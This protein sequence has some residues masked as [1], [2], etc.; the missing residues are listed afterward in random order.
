MVVQKSESLADCKAA[1]IRLRFLQGL[2][3]I[4]DLS[5]GRER[6]GGRKLWRCRTRVS[7]ALPVEVNV[8]VQHSVSQ[9]VPKLTPVQKRGDAKPAE[10][11]AHYDIQ[12]M[13]CRS[14]ILLLWRAV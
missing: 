9:L 1:H 14:T 12:V 8:W 7:N 13:Q 10:S 2:P 5:T 6:R 3:T 11:Y 4:V